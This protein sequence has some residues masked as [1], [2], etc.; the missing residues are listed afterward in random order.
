MGFATSIT[1]AILFLSFMVIGSIAYPVMFK[2]YENVQDSVNEKHKL[3]MSQ[4]NTRINILSSSYS[5]GKYDITVSNNGSTIMHANR[6]TVILDG[7]YT[8]YSVSP[9]GLW[10]PTDSVIFTITENDNIQHR[11]KIITE[12]GISEIGII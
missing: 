10:L 3:Q 6:S 8:S 12:N 5:G 9:T 2:S 4:L 7:K 1:V 11:L